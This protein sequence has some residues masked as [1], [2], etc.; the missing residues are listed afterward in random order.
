[1]QQQTNENNKNNRLFRC[2]FERGCC[3]F[4]EGGFRAFLAQWGSGEGRGS[5]WVVLRS[6]G[7]GGRRG[8]VWDRVGVALAGRGSVL[9]MLGAGLRGRL[10][11]AHSRLLCMHLWVL[12]HPNSHFP[13]R[14]L[15]KRL[16]IDSATAI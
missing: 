1:M 6:G 14:V 3:V 4:W 9:R 7:S 2:R 5:F 8:S 15:K 11:G 12:Y 16:H 10:P 13:I